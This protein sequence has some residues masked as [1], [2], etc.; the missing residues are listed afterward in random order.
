MIVGILVAL[1]LIFLFLVSF[2]ALPVIHEGLGFPIAAVAAFVFCLL[3]I[4]LVIGVLKKKI[5]GRLRKLLILTGV[6]AA[7]FLISVI[8]HN[9]FYALGIVFEKVTVLRYLMEGLHGAFFLIG[10]FGC[11]LGFLV[12]AVGSV[13]MFIGE[14]RRK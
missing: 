2:M 1:I 11:P 10:I 9:F 6:S 13:V 3:G 5:K 7:G 4:V 12:G 8:L 14:K